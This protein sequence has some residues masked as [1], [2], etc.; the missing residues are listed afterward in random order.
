[1][2]G[3]CVGHCGLDK[4]RS[5]GFLLKH[6]FQ[7]A[8]RD[9]E[10]VRDSRQVDQ[11]DRPGDDARSRAPG[12]DRVVAAPLA[13]RTGHRDRMRASRR[14]VAVR[15]QLSPSPAR[16]VRLRRAG[17]VRSGQRPGAAVARGHHVDH[18]RGP[19]RPRGSDG[20]PAAGLQPGRA[21]AGGAAAVREQQA[22]LP[23][24]VAQRRGRRPIRAV[25]D[26]A[27]DRGAARA[28]P[29]AIPAAD[30]AVRPG[31]TGRGPARAGR[32]RL[33]APVRSGGGL[34]DRR[35]GDR[36]VR[37]GRF[38]R[39]GRDRGRRSPAGDRPPPPGRGA[40]RCSQVNSRPAIAVV[41][42]AGERPVRLERRRRPLRGRAAVVRARASR[43]PDPARCRA[44]LLRHPA[45]LPD[46]GGR[47]PR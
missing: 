19:R 43:R 45:D 29:R 47:S 38:G 7:I 26:R 12:S 41:P 21:L 5:E 6:A 35:A 1:M 44:G 27:R 20:G 4:T 9:R 3:G 32:D 24:A 30:P 23:G 39:D 15:V 25:R 34:R 13:R 40:S 22:A 36:P 2:V 42:A 46:H 37:S 18:G 11:A 16:P 17:S 10:R 8:G 33:R 31:S 14:A 28:D